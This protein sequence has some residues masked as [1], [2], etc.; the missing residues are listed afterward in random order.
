MTLYAVRSSGSWRPG[1]D[2]H[3][4]G[5]GSTHPASPEGESMTIRTP[6]KTATGGDG[7]P[8]IP[9]P[10]RSKGRASLRVPHLTPAERAASGRAA[11]QLVPRSSHAELPLPADR[12]DP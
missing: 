7:V 4:R 11:R 8:L 6:A 5:A 10:T 12:P 1:T 2:G 9:G 3:R